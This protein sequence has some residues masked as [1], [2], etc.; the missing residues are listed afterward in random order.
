MDVNTVLSNPT[1]L[2]LM[3]IISTVFFFVFILVI[4]MEV[5]DWLRHRSLMKLAKEKPEVLEKIVKTEA[6]AKARKVVPE[7]VP[8]K[9]KVIVL[10]KDAQLEDICKYD[11]ELITCSKIKMQFLPPSDYKPKP[12][13]FKKKL[14]LTYY[15]TEDGKA[16][17]IDT[18]GIAEAKVP[19]PRMTEVIINRRLLY[20]VF[21]HLGFNISSVIMGVGLG[22]M[23]MAVVI[24]FVLPLVGV[25]VMVGRQP[26]EVIHV[27]QTYAAPL[28]SN[29][30]VVVP[31]G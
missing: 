12:T 1:T 20:Q 31:H 30:T 3:L 6:K 17:S 28:P 27:N 9:V 14:L 13:F 19:D 7:L 29:Y 18:S 5:S 10:Q 8:K 21:S 4:I 2:T 26:I 16:V 25:P 11:G 22:A 24:F 15:F 23:L